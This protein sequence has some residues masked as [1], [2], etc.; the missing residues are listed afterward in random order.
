MLVVAETFSWKCTSTK[1]LALIFSLTFVASRR[2]PVIR[3]LLFS[4][5]ASLSLS[6]FDCSASSV[7]FPFS[8]SL[9]LSLSL[10]LAPPL[11]L[12]LFLF[13]SLLVS[14]SLS[15]SPS[16]SLFLFLSLSLSLFWDNRFALSCFGLLGL[17]P[18]VAVNWSS[19]I[20]KSVTMRQKT[21]Q[22]KKEWDN[23]NDK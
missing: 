2:S 6:L 15:L 21:E 8:R 12:L 13:L 16:L 17:S 3:G 20:C 19:S 1:V 7:L 5:S 14:S 23:A 9:S 4:F 10:S 22:R 18:P 11:F